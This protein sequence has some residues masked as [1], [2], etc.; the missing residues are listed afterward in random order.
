VA[1]KAPIKLEP[2]AVP[3]YD[4]AISFLVADEKIAASLKAGLSGLNVF[5]YPHKQEE[6]IGTNGMESMREPFLKARVNVVLYR[7]RYGNTPWTGVELSAIQDSCLK[8]RFDSLIFVQLDKQDAVPDWLPNTHIRCV[9]G[10]FTIDQLVGGIKNKVLE[11]GGTIRRA[12]ATSE[13]FRVKQEAEYFADRD[14]LMRDTTWIAGVKASIGE[15]IT[16]IGRLVADLNANQQFQI[17]FGTLNSGVTV[18]RSG[19]VSMGI[20]WQQ[21]IINYVGDDR[22]HECHLWAAEFSG[23]LALPGEN[24]WYVEQP[25]KL[26]NHKFKVE[27]AQDR[28]LVWRVGGNKE[29]VP[30]SELADY[31]VRLFLN[32]ISR[33]NQGKIDPPRI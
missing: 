32:L 10:D 5:F 11:R 25:K 31:I 7:P 28:S 29:Y 6:L 18:L 2:A 17:G 9:L 8:S 20:G 13:A 12:D 19:Y 26:T 33:A 14:R 30:S 4:V 1:A 22:Q 27:V 21:P 16:E 23:L 15:T 3:D 24:R